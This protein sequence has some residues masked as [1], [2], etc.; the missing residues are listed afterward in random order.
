MRHCDDE[1][2]SIG[3]WA[4]GIAL[5]GMGIGLWVTSIGHEAL[6][7]VV[8]GQGAKGQ[9]ALTMQAHCMTAWAHRKWVWSWCCAGGLRRAE[10]AGDMAIGERASGEGARLR[11]VLRGQ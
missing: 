11:A 3:L 1:G 9:R 6:T 7:I 5:W 2:T 10:R 4:I 8:I